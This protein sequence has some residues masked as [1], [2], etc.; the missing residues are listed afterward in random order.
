MP[1][2]AQH[3]IE[4][5]ILPFIHVEDDLIL[6]TIQQPWATL[7]RLATSEDETVVVT[8]I[9]MPEDE[10]LLPT[11]QQPWSV[12]APSLDADD[13]V[14]FINVDEEYLTYPVNWPL[15]K[16]LYSLD[17]DEIF[18]VTAPTVVEEDYLISTL[19]WPYLRS[20]VFYDTDDTYSTIEEDV[21]LIE[22]YT[23]P[24]TK[25]YYSLDADDWVL[26]VTP[27]QAVEDEYLMI[28]N[29]WPLVNPALYPLP[30]EDLQFIFIAAV[31]APTG[32]S[33]WVPP[34]ISTLGLF[35]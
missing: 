16:V 34:F 27:P 4:G 6:P 35:R 30:P 32:D 20:S 13:W 1:R 12:W 29:W 19:Q 8:V 3:P 23:W 33:I 10:I 21:Q 11:I 26:F 28:P 25:P 17:M 2:I 14:P 5:D 24:P 22:S 31:V 18:A 7:A 9:P 15:Q